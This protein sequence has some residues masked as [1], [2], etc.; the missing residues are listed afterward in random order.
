MKEQRNQ[1]MARGVERENK[2]RIAHRYRVG[3]LVLI[4]HDMDGQVYPKQQRPTSGPYR[5]TA[6]RGST[7][8]VNQ[9]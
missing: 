6:I 1:Q 9:N 7:L 2:K 8:E 3:E 4:R 5:I